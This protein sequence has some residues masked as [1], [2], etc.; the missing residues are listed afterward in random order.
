MAGKS[1][2]GRNRRGAHTTANSSES[3]VSSDAP[4]KDN[5][6]ASES[7]KADSNGVSTLDESTNVT[8][9]IKESET[10]NSASQQ[11]QGEVSCMSVL[12]YAL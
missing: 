3:V 12:I 1:N 6:S 8:P 2:K 4:V 9:E 7:T 11:K 10:A 5:L